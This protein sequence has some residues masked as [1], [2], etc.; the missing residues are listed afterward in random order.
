[1]GGPVQSRRTVGLR[2]VDVRTL[3]DQGT[4]LV[5]VG[6]LDGRNQRY[7]GIGGRVADQTSHEDHCERQAEQAL[8]HG[9][10]TESGSSGS[11]PVLWPIL[12]KGTPI[13]SS[14]VRCRLASG[15]PS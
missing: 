9:Y 4:S 5:D 2:G 1:M 15:V 3:P 10:R 12:S 8:A 11:R 14:R 6:A 13:R 7:V